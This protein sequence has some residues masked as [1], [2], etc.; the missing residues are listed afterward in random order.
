MAITQKMIQAHEGTLEVQ[1]IENK[2]TTVIIC[3][4]LSPFK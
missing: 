4:P 3:L 2:R 1:C